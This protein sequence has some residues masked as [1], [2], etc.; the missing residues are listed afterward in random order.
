M[1]ILTVIRHVPD[2]RAS[3]KLRP[4]GSGIETTGLRF[5]CDPFDEFGVEFA[6]R[7]S[8]QRQ[9]IESITALT[10]GPPTAADAL[11]HAIAMG[12]NRAAHVT[13]ESAWDDEIR[14]AQVAAAFCRSQDPG[15]DLILCGKQATDT[16]AGVIGPAIAELLGWPHVG[17]VTSVEFS[18][19]ARSLTARRRIEGAEEVVRATLPVLLTCEKGLVE[20]R[21]PA[22]PKLMK[23]KKHPI[24]T[25]SGPDLGVSATG[26]RMT[27]RRL[28]APPPRPAC[29]MI[30]GDPETMAKEL[31]RRLREEARV[32]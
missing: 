24:E 23:A 31:V 30:G 15:F 13:D 14:L 32:V 26:M 2:S 22:L 1:R 4:D 18:D 17:A 20:P 11:R 27:R 8:E 3:V 12:A 21:Q 29:T 9:D 10:I 7:L 19:D 6:V 5:V 25:M 16:D 28:A